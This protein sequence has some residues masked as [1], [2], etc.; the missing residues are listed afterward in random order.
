[1]MQVEHIVYDDTVVAV[2]LLR[3]P[4]DSAK[5]LHMAIRW[6]PPGSVRHSDGSE[7]PLTNLMGGETDWFII[8]FTYAAAIGRTMVQQKAAGMDE[9]FQD[10]GFQ[11]LVDWLVQAEELPDA[12]CY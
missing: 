8:P 11:A 4:R 2:C 7:K 3:L 10:P 1:V 12:M 5:T 6:T 9:D